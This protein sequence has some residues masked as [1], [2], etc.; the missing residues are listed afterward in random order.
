MIEAVS[1]QPPFRTRFSNGAEHATSDTTAD[2]GGSGGGF[3]PHELLEAA[4][5]TC[6]NMMVRMYAEN[7]G[8]PLVGVTTT[9]D[10]DRSDPDEVV[11]RYDI[12][13][14]GLLSAEQKERLIRAGG[15]CPVRRTLSKRIRFASRTEA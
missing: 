6:V 5:A 13:L 3:R 4:M 8:V 1:E 10:L 11:F 12:R 7:H 15:A 9:V 14:D 2:K